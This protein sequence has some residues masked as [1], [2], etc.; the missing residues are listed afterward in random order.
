MRYLLT[1][2][3]GLL[4]TELRNQAPDLF[5]APSHE[6]LDITKINDS[7]VAERIRKDASIT[8][9]LHAAAF[10]SPP[11]CEENKDLAF[12]TNVI[13]TE[14]LARWA[15]SRGIYRPRF[16]FVL[17]STDYVYSGKHGFHTEDENPSPCNYYAW[18]KLMQE[19]VVRNYTPHLIIRTTFAKREP[20]PFPKAFVDHFT[21]KDFVDVIAAR[22]IDLIKVDAA[23]G[24]V[25]IGTERKSL[26][27]LAR[28]VSPEVGQMSIKDLPFTVPDD[29]SLDC[30]KY[31]NIVH[32]NTS[33]LNGE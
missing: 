18:T 28:K 32:K 19:I 10:T 7:I 33:T 23:E 11:K 31:W 2:G 25:N 30:S 8:G 14:N 1:G 6:D 17:I 9:I 20:W 27:D 5:V 15:D 3:S 22:I 29:T 26:Y 21:S 13:G 4:C 12:E 16:K 24:V